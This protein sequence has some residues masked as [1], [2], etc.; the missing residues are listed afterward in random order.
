MSLP[1]VLQQNHSILLLHPLDLALET[2]TGFLQNEFQDPLV[3]GEAHVDGMMTFGEFLMSETL[4]GVTETGEVVTMVSALP[5]SHLVSNRVIL[6]TSLTDT[7]G[8]LHS[9]LFGILQANGN[10]LIFLSTLGITQAEY[11]RIAE[12]LPD[13]IPLYIGTC[14]PIGASSG[15][16]IRVVTPESRDEVTDD[17]TSLLPLAVYPRLRALVRDIVSQSN[18]KHLVLAGAHLLQ[19][20]AALRYF[21]VN[22]YMENVDEFN[23]LSS[24]VY[25]ARIPPIGLQGI[26]H[27]HFYDP[28]EHAL[29]TAGQ[30]YQNQS[31]HVDG[32]GNS[33]D[34]A[35]HISNDDDE[36]G[37]RA[38]RIMQDLSR[39]VEVWEHL[40]QTTFRITLD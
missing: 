26:A 29:F 32:S 40:L 30:V 20:K 22:A 9:S 16:K 19:I 3:V 5:H 8:F 28:D 27:L 37:Y 38:K 25:L 2:I 24:G 39:A 23:A 18:D 7:L 21:G 34:V 33:F 14:D 36:S 15:I 17:E 13:T 10:H 11:N 35:L 31:C 6:F 4:Q 1:A 12:L